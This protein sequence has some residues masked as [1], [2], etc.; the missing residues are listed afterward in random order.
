MT[1]VWR[2]ETE[3]RD[4][5]RANSRMTRGSGVAVYIVVQ[6]GESGGVMEVGDGMRLGQGR[7]GDAP[8]QSVHTQA[9][10]LVTSGESEWQ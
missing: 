7:C 6:E 4:R 1:E 8:I 3:T 9:N 10:F 5:M 2:C